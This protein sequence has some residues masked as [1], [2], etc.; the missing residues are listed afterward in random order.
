MHDAQIN[1]DVRRARD[2][3]ALHVETRF[4]GDI[5]HADRRSHSRGHCRVDYCFPDD[6]HRGPSRC[7]PPAAAPDDHPIAHDCPVGESDEPPDG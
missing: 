6:I 1:A 3:S 4:R 7:A 2:R 5:R